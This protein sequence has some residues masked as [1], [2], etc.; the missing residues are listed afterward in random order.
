MAFLTGVIFLNA[1]A[2]ALNN[3]GAD[4]SSE[5]ENAIAAKTVRTKEGIFPYVSAQA[6]RYWLR[7]TLER[8]KPGGWQTAP[9]DR[10]GKIA[11]TDGNPLDYHDDDLFGYMRAQ[12]KSA[13]AK[14]SRD[15]LSSALTPVSTTITRVSPLRVSTFL[16]LASTTPTQDFG[17]MSRHEGD[18]VPHEHQFYHAV[19]K[20]LFSLD[21]RAAGTFSYQNRTGY[22]NLDD[23]RIKK[24][25]DKGLEHLE[26]EKSYRLPVEERRKRVA[27][28]LE[29]LA[30]LSG[31]AKQTLHY[32]DVTPAIVVAMVTKGGNNP[33]QYVIG[34]DKQGLPEVKVDALHQMIKAWRDQIESPLYVG[35]VEGFCDEQ[36]KSLEKLLAENIKNDTALSKLPHGYVLDHPRL[37]LQQIA[38]D[39][40]NSDNSWLA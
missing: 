17:V 12:G 36:R 34:P 24:A 19:L 28:L 15:A 16:A 5:N 7:T 38:T 33:L 21:L 18:P 39:F 25:Q 3:A 13:A 9:I 11:Y 8:E 32:T 4:K 35:W 40:R 22:L 6:F 10:E 30:I 31:G 20:G 27:A 26:A 29:G 14:A 2:A 37:V 1:P 23:N